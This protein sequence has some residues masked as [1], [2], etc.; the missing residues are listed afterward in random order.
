MGFSTS[1]GTIRQRFDELWDTYNPTIPYTFDDQGESDFPSRDS[2]W[3]RLSILNGEGFQVEMG[4]TNRW[5]Y[6]GIAVVQLFVPKGSG[7]GLAEQVADSMK[8]I[9]QGRTI[10]GVV[11]KATSLL[12]AGESEPWVQYNISTPFHFDTLE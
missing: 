1:N 8:L 9:F 10:S 11:F 7:T 12:K 6:P 2:A 5:R 3:A 4:M